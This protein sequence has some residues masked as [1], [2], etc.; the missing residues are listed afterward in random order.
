MGMRMQ[1]QM[2]PKQRKEKPFF[3]FIFSPNALKYLNTLNSFITA[4]FLGSLYII[5]IMLDQST[6]SRSHF[7]KSKRWKQYRLF[8]FGRIRF[9]PPFCNK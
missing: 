6:H 2:Q 3:F 4:L 7:Q 1:V 9:F 8:A 5:H